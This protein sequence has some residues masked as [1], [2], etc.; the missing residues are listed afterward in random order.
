M[1]YFRQ[2]S[3]FFIY[4]ITIL[5]SI[6]FIPNMAYDIDVTCQDYIDKHMS[7]KSRKKIQEYKE[8]CILLQQKGDIDALLKEKNR[9]YPRTRKTL[10]KNKHR[11]LIC[12]AIVEK[13]YFD[14]ITKMLHEIAH[15]PLEKASKELEILIYNLTEQALEKNIF[16]GAKITEWLIKEYGFDVRQTA[17]NSYISRNDHI[18]IT[19][20][21]SIFSNNLKN[22]LS[23]IQHHSLPIA[24]AELI[25]LKQQ[26]NEYLISHNITDPIAQKNFM[27]N[28]FNC[29]IIELAY[30][31]YRGRLDH[32]NLISYFNSF[33]V[34]ETIIGILNNQKHDY[35][36]RCHEFDKVAYWVF[37][38]A[39]L[40]NL[41]I[42]PE[43]TSRVYEALNIIKKSCDSA[44]FIPRITFINN[45]LDEI[46]GKVYSIVDGKPISKKSLEPFTQAIEK[47]ITRINQ[48]ENE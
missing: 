15:A 32:K 9:L 37:H 6:I 5:L 42:A 38:N 23:I 20:Y 4:C 3:L 17:H 40:C 14:P 31:L 34:Q 21:E 39:K 16:Q 26:I 33:G 2:K 28:N 46:Q 36:S 27:I 12:L 1:S 18:D 47:F 44:E 25:H 43:I 45:V 48:H 7:V 30:N 29:N 19:Q 13:I 11:D 10:N 8:R 24:Y 35:T 41:N 22:I